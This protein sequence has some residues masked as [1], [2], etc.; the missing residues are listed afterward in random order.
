MQEE[1]FY[2]GKCARRIQTGICCGSFR[3]VYSLTS[4][5]PSLPHQIRIS[6]LSFIS[7]SKKD[8]EIGYYTCIYIIS[9]VEHF[10][11]CFMKVKVKNLMLIRLL[12]P[13][14][15]Q[16]T[17]LSHNRRLVW[18]QLLLFYLVEYLMMLHQL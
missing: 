8:K 9:G 5:C 18:P 10:H 4:S 14:P 15:F 11:G 7:L 3:W 2:S 1:G 6:G 12:I 13:V 17:S 16:N